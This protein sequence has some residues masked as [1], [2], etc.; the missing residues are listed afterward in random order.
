MK[1]EA[2]ST[3]RDTKPV[4]G[5]FLGYCEHTD[6]IY[7][8]DRENPNEPVRLSRNYLGKSFHEH[9]AVQTEP[10][11][12]SADSFELLQDEIKQLEANSYLSEDAQALPYREPD[13][14]PVERLQHWQDLARFVRDRREKYAQHYDLSPAGAEQRVKEEWKLCDKAPAF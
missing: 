12:A 14:V 2:S 7:V 4:K 1:T 9:C 13:N 6:G 11:G 5:V 8:W 10:I 3:Q